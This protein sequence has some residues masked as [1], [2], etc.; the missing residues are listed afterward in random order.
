[1]KYT[2]YILGLCMSTLLVL[3]SCETTELD[4]TDNPNALSPSQADPTFFLNSIQIDFAFW[5]NSMGERGAELTRINYL[6]GRTYN[7]I[8]SPD[9]WNGIWSSAYRGMLE[10]IRLMNLLAEEAGLN[11]HRGMGKVFEAYILMTLVDYFGDIPYTEALQGGEGIL[12]P[13]ADS[14]ASVYSAA[15][16]LLDSS[17]ADFIAEGPVP[18]NDYFY[19]GD[20]S[21]WIKAANSIKKKAL[22]NQGDFSAYNAISNYIS[23]P[24]DDFQFSWGTSAATPDTRHPYYRSSY[25]ST[26]GNEYM[27]NW[28]MFK[29]L[30]GHGG[31]T[32]PRINYYFYRQVSE[33]PG[34]DSAAN[35]EVLECGLPGYYVPPQLRGDD[36]PFCAP[37]NSASKPAG[38]YWG[39]DHGN[40][41]GIP[42]DG[43][44][45]TLRGVYPAGGTFDD[46]SFS[47]QIAG[48][49]L[50]GAGITP[51]MLSSWMHFMNAEVAVST[52]GDPTTETLTAL[53]QA[54][55][56]A[57]DLGGPEMAQEDVDAYIAA[58]TS[59]W[60]AAS[61]VS[62]K[63]DMWATEFFISMAGNGIDAYNSYR[64]NGFPRDVQPN[65]E[66]DPGQF[67]LI[68][69]YPAN[70][71]NTNKNASQRANKNERVFW[72]SN[73][74][75]NLK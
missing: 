38:G 69:Y 45:K 24:E 20:A 72:N 26:G 54:L 41:N 28:M 25:T 8:Y 67:P 19:G 9:S 65:I 4:L 58:F 70:Y 75:S 66:P 6:S 23:E 44:L 7:N 30:N 10:D 48:D 42:P 52:G 47:G 50:A 61:S 63:L 37:T 60:S 34:F 64:R 68:Q 29:M 55:N 35:E 53:E 15:I 13:E 14:G 2:N 22:L 3:V 32:D 59:D 18:S 51:V 57:D 21:K 12:N 46:R 11:Y 40:D 17:I 36:T 27:S 5:V 74:P 56:K 31:N 73:G 33:T 62:E 39:R 43:F 71:V 1:M 16:A 49:G